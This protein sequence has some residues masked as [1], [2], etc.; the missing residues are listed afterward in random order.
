MINLKNIDRKIFRTAYN[1]YRRKG[2]PYVDLR[3][4]ELL[5]EYK[6]VLE[7]KPQ[8]TRRYDFEGKT[9]LSVGTSNQGTEFCRHFMRH[10]YDVRVF[11]SAG[12]PVDAFNKRKL[13]LK[14]IKMNY[15][16]NSNISDIYLRNYLARVE[17][18]QFATNFR[19]VAAKA[20][21]ER[22]LKNNSITYDYCSG[23]GGRLLG[24]IT[25]KY[26]KNSIYIGV[27]PS[28]K[29]YNGLREMASFCEAGE[30]RVRIFKECAEDFLPK[31]YIG[32]V[33]FAFSSPPYFCKELYSDEDTQSYKRYP[34]YSSWRK[35]FL[36]RTIK[37][38]F[39]LLKQNGF[40]AINIANVKIKGKLYPCGDDAIK[41]SERIFGK[42]HDRI[43]LPM[44][45]LFGVEGAPKKMEEIFVF[46]KENRK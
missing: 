35:N 46:K 8:I 33:D 11:A 13:L 26:F 12:S 31:E 4:Y 40:F 44:N 6:K 16:Y 45:T 22:F 7:A 36:K 14:S 28:T 39:C 21:Y 2:F 9:Y 17:W 41:F 42:L 20:I 5:L 43:A 29:S 24:F 37:N 32:N 3:P 15:F 19:P 1:Y 38:C 27:D 10:Q 25:N 18:H 30:N 34:E 23:F